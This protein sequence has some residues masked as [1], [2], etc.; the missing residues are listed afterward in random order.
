MIKMFQKR[1]EKKQK[2][3]TVH[4][5][6]RIRD[7][8]LDKIEQYFDM[9]IKELEKVDDSILKHIFNMARLGLSFEKEMNLSQRATE[10]NFIRIANMVTESKKEMKQ[11]IR[12][13]L[14]Q[15]ADK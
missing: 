13:T 9:N 4:K 6:D 5:K 1:K 3:E 7:K 15:Y 11:Y 14:P 2:L 8:G 10:N 12:K